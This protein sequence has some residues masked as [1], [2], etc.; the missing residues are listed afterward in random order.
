[1]RMI[2]IFSAG[3]YTD[4][5]LAMNG[6]LWKRSNLFPLTV[7]LIQMLTVKPSDGNKKE[8]SDCGPLLRPAVS[9]Q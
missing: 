2:N 9:R 4:R 8:A 7:R 3:R 6:C 5:D 1:M